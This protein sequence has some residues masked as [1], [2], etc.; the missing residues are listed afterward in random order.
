MAHATEVDAMVE[1][2]KTP[3]RKGECRMV[4]SYKD[5]LVEEVKKM[6]EDLAKT[7]DEL[8]HMQKKTKK[9]G[10]GRKFSNDEGCYSCGEQG[11]F[12][13][14]CSKAK[15]SMQGNESRWLDQ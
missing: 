11:H 8:K 10:T 5:D 13:R 12:I 4:G 15:E 6:P 3:R 9:Q 14:N 2:E 7:K 1:A